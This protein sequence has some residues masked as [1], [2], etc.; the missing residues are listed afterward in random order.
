[1]HNRNTP[2]YGVMNA[3][4]LECIVKR[5]Y[6]EVDGMC[7]FSFQGG[8]PT[9]AGL[10][11]FKSFIAFVRQYNTN[12]IKTNLAIQTNGCIVD[13]DWARF[14]FENKFLVGLS[15]DGYKDLHDLYRVDVKQSGTFDGVLL[16]AELFVKYNVEF[17]ILTVV[18]AQVAKH[19]EKIYRF[20]KK[21]GFV[22][23][24]YI[25]CL[26]PLGEE[27]GKEQYSLTPQLYAQFLKSLFDLWYGDFIA[28][29]FVY[30][31]YFENL[32]GIQLGQAPEA[33]SMLG[34]C[35]KQIVVEADGSVYPCDFYVLD[36]YCIGNLVT[37][38]FDSIEQK[39]SLTDF[40]KKSEQVNDACKECKWYSLCHGGCRRDRDIGREHFQLNYFCSAYKAFFQYA[41]S[42]LQ[43]IAGITAQH[44]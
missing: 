9:L 15:L 36:Q 12:N 25:P 23:Q 32:V 8:E 29:E 16:A 1:M 18:T 6:A 20:F 2:S 5:V 4:T 26:D 44:L 31:R 42:R 22:Y 14:F 21:K 17:N 10:D 34:H 27:R 43:R 33:C 38:N 19:V 40:I 13:E 41:Y 11:F 28:G 35:S 3:D 37:D 24:Q 39:R 7:T 30:N